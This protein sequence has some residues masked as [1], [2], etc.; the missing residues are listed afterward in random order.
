MKREET[1]GPN[2][3]ELLRFRSME[4]KQSHGDEKE[5]AERENNLM[6]CMIGTAYSLERIS[7]TQCREGN[8]NKGQQSP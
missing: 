8:P 2:S 6:S 4:K 7:R 3:G 1:Q 5:L